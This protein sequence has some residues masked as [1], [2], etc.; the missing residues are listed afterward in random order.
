MSHERFPPFLFYQFSDLR[1]FEISNQHIKSID[2]D[3]FHNANNLVYLNI[4]GNEIENI[5]NNT[6][7]N[8][9][10]I[11]VLDL[12]FNNIESIDNGTFEH[13]NLTKLFLDHNKLVVV[14]WDQLNST[15]LDVLKLNDNFISSISTENVKNYTKIIDLSN[16][17]LANSKNAIRLEG[18]LV[19]IQNTG[20]QKLVVYPQIR[21][22]KAQDNQISTIILENGENERIFELKTFNLSN[23]LLATISNLS[24]LINLEEIDLSFN[25]LDTFDGIVFSK[26]AKLRII[27]AKSNSLKS[28]DF[29]S[30]VKLKFLDISSNQLTVFEMNSMAPSLQ[31]LHIYDNHVSEIDPHIKKK[32]PQL[33]KI[34][35]DGNNFTCGYVK[36]LVRTLKRGRI[37]VVT[38]DNVPYRK[39]TGFVK[40]IPCFHKYDVPIVVQPKCGEENDSSLNEDEEFIS[41][42]LDTLLSSFNKKFDEMGLKMKNEMFEYMKNVSLTQSSPFSESD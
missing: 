24:K 25:K 32:L 11:S 27:T 30:L 41:S 7:K 20:I 10:N 37:V 26:M 21:H 13:L 39:H 29:T 40:G 19:S 1:N 23:N 8:A 9:G 34:G 31:E 5:Y 16:N 6:F 18:G 3:D 15:P 42:T 36:G 35:L 17:P 14:D 2:G 22:L 4:S 28:F 38:N 12:S 33:I